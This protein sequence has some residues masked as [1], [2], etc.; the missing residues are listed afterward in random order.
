[1]ENC[2]LYPE[3]F[4][5]MMGERKFKLA[6][7]LAGVI[8]RTYLLTFLGTYL[9]HKWTRRNLIVA[10]NQDGEKSHTKI[11]PSRKII[12]RTIKGKILGIAGDVVCYT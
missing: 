4:I 9:F 6:D 3:K 5:Q 10:G 2:S 1:M 7:F 12:K 11:K 8:F